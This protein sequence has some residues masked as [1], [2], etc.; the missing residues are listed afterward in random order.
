MEVFSWK[1]DWGMQFFIKDF[2]KVK[3]VEF[4]RPELGIF[5]SDNRLNLEINRLNSI[6]SVQTL[7]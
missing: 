4:L 1:C 2:D 7:N 3:K 6:S 5:V